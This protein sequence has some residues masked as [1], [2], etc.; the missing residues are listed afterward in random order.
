M[1]CRVGADEIDPAPG[2]ASDIGLFGVRKARNCF[3]AQIER[4][5]LVYLTSD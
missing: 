4:G 1:R 5:G 3:V 2:E